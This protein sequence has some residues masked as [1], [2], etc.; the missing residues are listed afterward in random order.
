MRSKV[1]N[2]LLGATLAGAAFLGAKAD[3]EL[4]ACSEEDRTENA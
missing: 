2:V 1:I 4:Y 3:E